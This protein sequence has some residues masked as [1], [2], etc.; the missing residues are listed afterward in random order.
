MTPPALELKPNCTAVNPP[1][2][3]TRSM[4]S[5][6]LTQDLGICLHER[7]RLLTS[8]PAV[9]SN[10]KSSIHH[11]AAMYRDAGMVE[12]SQIVYLFTKDPLTTSMPSIQTILDQSRTPLFFSTLLLGRNSSEESS[13]AI[14][15][16]LRQCDKMH[17][18]R[19][20][21]VDLPWTSLAI[22]YPIMSN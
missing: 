6:Q 1:M 5:C 3:F 2:L 14:S 7:P 9:T 20:A 12:I 21:L 18:P 10:P 8:S 16:L 13:T 22:S 17:Q 19:N 11:H 15:L 4:F